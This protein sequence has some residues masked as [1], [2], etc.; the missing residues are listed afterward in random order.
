MRAHDWAATPLGPPQTWPE[1]LKVPLRMMLTSRFEMWLGW[2]PDLAFFYNDAYIPTLGVKHPA[3]L[4]APM[5]QV[6]KEV[7]A[8]VEDR[9][10]SVMRD[11]VATWDKAL[12]LIL[13]RSGLPEETYHTFSYSPLMGADGAVGGLMCVV[14]EE[15]ER[16]ISERR[17]ETL[18]SVATGLLPV[19]SREDLM[20]GMREALTRNARDFPFGFIHLFDG[21]ADA[22]ASPALLAAPWPFEALPKDGASLRAPLAGLLDAPPQGDW[23][24]P[25]REA[26]I[27]PI[28]KTGQKQPSGVLV[29]GLNP[30]RP[31]D[32]DIEG[33]AELI[34][35][36]VAGALA[37][38]DAR[39]NEVRQTAQLRE[40][41]EQS[42]SFMAIL[43]GPQHRFE[44]VNPGYLQLIAHRDV[45]GR[46]IREALPEV[47]EQGFVNLLTEVYES[48]QPHVGQSVEVFLQRTPGAPPEPR[49]LDFVY[50]P[51]RDAAGAVTGVFV[52]GIDVTSAH[53]AVVALRKSEAEFRTLAEAMP[54]HVWAARPDGYLDWFN[55]G[56]YDYGGA[57]PGELDGDN[58]GD[59]VH[60]DDLRAAAERWAAAVASGETYEVEFRLRRAD[61]VYRWHISRAVPLR[62]EAGEIVRWI[63]TNTDIEDQK[64]ATR[65]LAD[66]NATLEQQVQ[67]RT[68]ELMAAEE[69][70]RQSQKME[71]V[72]QLTGGIAHDFNNLLTGITGSLDLLQ[73][74]ID[75]GRLDAAP[76]Y[77]DAAQG[78][79]KRAAALTQRLLAFA[80]RQT[81]NP[82][83]V[84]VNRLIA[85]LDDLIRRTMG[86][87]VEMEVVG[88]GGLWATR[89]DPN[90]LENAILNLCINAR[91]AMPDGGRLTIETANKWLDERAARER[92][93]TPGQ[94][95]SICVT[96][97]GSGMTPDVIA[98]A[99]DPFFTTKPLGQG[100]GLGLSMI[101]GFV[102]QSGGQ[103]RIYSEV[104][105]GTTMCLYLPRSATDAAE[106]AGGSGVNRADYGGHGETVL[107]IDDE[108]TIR[109]LIVDVLEEAGYRALEA[110]D[111][112]AG[113]KIL[114]SDV[115]VDLLITD[116]GL[117]GGINGRQ[118]AD[119]GRALRPELKV[120]FITGYAENAV[121]GNG[122]LERGMQ[123][124]TKPFAVEALGDKIRQMIDG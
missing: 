65:A 91:D 96:D 17:L 34:A 22:G 7:F 15:T 53:D 41:F 37:T 90:Q 13:E 76:R 43:R 105:K 117:P 101:Y 40:L 58:W 121:V 52:E 99:F 50:Q 89:V 14:T 45:L 120:L 66:L 63:G 51:V 39:L 30:Y 124:I 108:P 80:R 116:V 86:P 73:T 25:P 32:P 74:R 75:Q 110:V 33:F 77:I 106:P 1:G 94:Y 95:V 104:G 46:D 87:G 112:P 118:V 2:G 84:N 92:E 85:G 102:R 10:V 114:E 11:G 56:I 38:V 23:D 78:A 83:A 48:G 109:M 35:G 8:D 16:V 69:A 81:L 42:P 103:V 82:E 123:V 9:I 6:W 21:P 36:Q 26:L 93:L 19:R 57:K 60:Q 31:N 79:A 111:G 98:R 20:A 54:D 115:R 18:R 49:Y 55:S 100:T 68:D 119:A 70:L 24:R 44:L 47:V 29:L 72:G 113:L 4:G 28:T 5:A 67:A 27:V 122:H 62:N 88:A 64:A 71:A 12:L 3:A 97:T 61:G 59:Y 107:V